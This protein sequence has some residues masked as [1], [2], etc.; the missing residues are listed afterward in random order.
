M[1]KFLRGAKGI[2]RVLRYA[3][4]HGWHIQR[5]RSGHIRLTKPGCATVFTSCTPSDSQRASLNAISQLRRAGRDGQE[6]HG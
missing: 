3:R 2:E 4:S 6:L 5:T 1:A